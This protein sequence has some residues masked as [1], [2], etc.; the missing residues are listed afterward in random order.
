MSDFSLDQRQELQRLILSLKEKRLPQQTLEQAAP[1]VPNLGQ[2][3][4]HDGLCRGLYKAGGPALLLDVRSPKEFALDGLPDAVNLPVLDNEERHAVGLLYKQQSQE[5]AVQVAL[6]FW[7]LKK[8]RFLAEAAKLAAGRP[9]ALY[10]WR[11]G[12][13]SRFS[14]HQLRLAGLEVRQ[15]VG[16]QKDW[17]RRVHAALYQ[18]AWSFLCLDGLTGCGKTAI[19]EELRRTHPQVPQIDFEAAAAHA[20][21]VFGRVRFLDRDEPKQA[22]FEEALFLQLMPF[23]RA[24]G[25]FPVFLC[26]SESR[27]IGSLQIPPAL[28]QARVSAPQIL[29]KCSLEV[30]VAR[31]RR[32]YFHD[33]DPIQVAAV[34]DKVALLTR[35]LGHDKIAAW[36]GLIDAGR[37]DEFSA[38]ILVNWYDRCYAQT[39]GTVVLEVD[40]ADVPKAAAQIA[41]LMKA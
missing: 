11:G 34:R 14:T 18:Q 17:R 6:H 13:R 38:D 19:L 1:R 12:G 33:G 40:S 23:R 4:L 24:D 3:E 22:R 21:S 7:E 16:G 5:L 9:V 41:A 31:I 27:K 10:C 28:W 20:S 30:R 15:L 8:D 37:Y 32:E 35:H 29:V 25:S 39:P 36:I 2:T 26:E